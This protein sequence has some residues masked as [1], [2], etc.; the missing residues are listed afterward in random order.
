MVQVTKPGGR[1]VCG[2][3]DWRSFQIDVTGAGAGGASS[4]VKGTEAEAGRRWGEIRRPPA[5]LAFDMGALTTKILNGAIP[6]LSA[7]SFIGLS[8]FRLL[9]AAGLEDVRLEVVPLLFHDR[10]TLEEIVPITYFARVLAVNQGAINADE[11]AMWL[12]RLAW[13]EKENLNPL[14]GVLNMYIASGTRPKTNLVFNG[15]ESKRLPRIFQLDKKAATTEIAVQVTSLINAAYAISDTGITL[16][17]SRIPQTEVAAMIKKGEIL[18]AMD[19]DA[20]V[21]CIQVLV[22]GDKENKEDQEDEVQNA[23]LP[24]N[25]SGPVGEFTCLAVADSFV[26]RGLGESLVRAAEAS[27]RR[28]GCETMLLGVMCPNVSPELEPEYKKWLQNWY[29]K[30]GYDHSSTI[31]LEFAPPMNAD[32]HNEVDQLNDM[33]ACLRQLVPCKAILMDK[34]L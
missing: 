6:R 26:G 20:L 31:E 7:H 18:A 1:V 30:L 33:Y 27:A 12:E 28:A 8:S 25:H 32:E 3:P 10:Q 29:L 15:V 23:G 9:K 22:K 5:A 21:G 17:T 24:A 11:A 4:A 34:T 14:C 19:G 16:S 13:E 2:N